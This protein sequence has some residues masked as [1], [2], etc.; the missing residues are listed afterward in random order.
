MM[1]ERPKYNLQ[2]KNKVTTRALL[3]AVVSGY[4]LFL[5]WQIIQGAQSEDTSMSKPVAFLIG[6]VFALAAIVFGV[7]IWKQYQAGLKDAELTP[8]ELEE[9]QD[10]AAEWA[11]EDDE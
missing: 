7:Y 6:G 10:L 9:E 11:E 1:R 8:E 4:L 2:R 3:R 5:S